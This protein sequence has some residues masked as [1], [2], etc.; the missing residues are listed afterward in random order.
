[1]GDSSQGSSPE[2]LEVIS[3][4]EEDKLFESGVKQGQRILNDI[5]RQHPLV[6]IQFLI[7]FS[8]AFS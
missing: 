1:M 3:E 5:I 7:S 4:D 6:D 2:Q 8:I